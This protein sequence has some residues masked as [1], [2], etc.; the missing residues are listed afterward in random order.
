MISLYHNLLVWCARAKVEMTLSDT[1]S[2]CTCERGCLLDVYFH[3]C[4]IEIYTCH[5][6]LSIDCTRVLDYVFHVYA[7][8]FYNLLREVELLLNMT[9]FVGSQSF[10]SLPSS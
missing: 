9:L 8:P 2:S 5:L 4:C 3:G 10:I 6:V 7:C 1:H